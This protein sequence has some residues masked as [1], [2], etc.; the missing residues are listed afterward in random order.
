[1]NPHDSHMYFTGPR[2]AWALGWWSQ[3]VCNGVK[4]LLFERVT[5]GGLAW[6]CLG[7]RGILGCDGLWFA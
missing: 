3:A 1:M 2:V 6:V 5:F 4:Q 7:L